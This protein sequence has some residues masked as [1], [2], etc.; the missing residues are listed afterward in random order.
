MYFISYLSDERSDSQLYAVQ[1][2]FFGQ[3]LLCG[4]RLYLY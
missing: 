2:A 3:A 1:Y 4:L